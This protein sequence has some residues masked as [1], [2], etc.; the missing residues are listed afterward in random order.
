MLKNMNKSSLILP[1]SLLLMVV[2]GC[3]DSPENTGEAIDP[4]QTNNG[5]QQVQDFSDPTEQG[6]TPPPPA[7]TVSTNPDQRYTQIT[8]GSSV[9]NRNPFATIIAPVTVDEPQNGA[10]NVSPLPTGNLDINGNRGTA[11]GLT[12][13]TPGTR[14][15][16]QR[17]T[18]PTGTTTPVS[19]KVQPT[20]PE[21][22]SI[23]LNQTPTTKQSIPS[24]IPIPPP[25]ALTPELP[26]GTIPTN[27]TGEIR[28]SGSVPQRKPDFTL[29]PI[30]KPEP[31]QA[32]AVAVTGILDI[33]G[34]KH[35]IVKAPGEAHSRYVRTGD[36]LA[37]GQVLVKRIITDKNNSYVVLEQLGQE[38]PLVAG[39]TGV[40]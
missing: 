19:K 26:P 11:N 17:T 15:T 20:K 23:A 29:A 24:S 34:E 38:V 16:S 5:E 9:P 32:R 25:P 33:N 31:D 14:T 21:V 2:S 7:L 37:N 18:S 27:P 10:I 6:T 8:K 13:G 12:S 39:T 3:K 35:A 40:E 4:N 30:P 28:T 1:I 36:R 22:T